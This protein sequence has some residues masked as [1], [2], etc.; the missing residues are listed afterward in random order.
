MSRAAVLVVLLTGFFGPVASAQTPVPIKALDEAIRKDPNNARGYVERCAALIA[1]GQDAPAARDCERAI[2]INPNLA[3]AYELRGRLAA[4]AGKGD[5]ALQEFTQALK[6]RPTLIVTV[7]TLKYR[8]ILLMQRREFVLAEKDFD[9]ATKLAPAR[10]DV[11]YGR[12]AARRAMGAAVPGDI[13]IAAAKQLQPEIAE[14]MEK[15]G[16]TLR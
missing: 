7:E 1:T 5:E 3:E 9:A 13:D 4:R 16:L 6:L 12:G 15:E 2:Q 8:G 14:Q 10:A 11:R